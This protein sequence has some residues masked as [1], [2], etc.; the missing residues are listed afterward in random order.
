MDLLDEYLKMN[1]GEITSRRV[2]FKYN[3]DGTVSNTREIYK[4]EPATD[5][6]IRGVMGLYTKD[7]NSINFIVR[8]SIENG[9]DFG[10]LFDEDSVRFYIDSPFE[11]NSDSIY[12]IQIKD[13]CSIKRIYRMEN[14]IS[15]ESFD[16]LRPIFPYLDL[17]F[18]MTRNDGQNYFRFK[19]QELIPYEIMKLIT[20][21]KEMKEWIKFHANRHIPVWIQ[22]SDTC[23]TIYYKID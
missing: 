8:R 9:G 7:K 10:V 15:L 16:L 19:S 5:S 22:L 18:V 6:M 4:I 11:L 20:D 17:S 12:S 13:S 1:G 2:S 14:I 21:N 3:F 23:I